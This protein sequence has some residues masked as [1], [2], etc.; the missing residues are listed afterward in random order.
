MPEIE[1]LIGLYI[2]FNSRDQ[3]EPL[4]VHVAPKELLGTSKTAKLWIR[5]DGSTKLAYNRAGISSK[6]LKFIQEMLQ[7]EAI[8][9]KTID[10][11]IK[12][13]EPENGKVNFY[14]KKD[15]DIER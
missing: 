11:Y 9:K 8:F 15:L 13:F 1:F 10:L 3:G 12:F 14:K 2:Y 6:K 5:E 4:H 7:T